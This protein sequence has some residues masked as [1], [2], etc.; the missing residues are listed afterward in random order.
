MSGNIY[1]QK[2]MLKLI[3]LPSD[4]TPHIKRS[5]RSIK[6]LG[7][8]KEFRWPEYLVQFKTINLVKWPSH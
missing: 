3:P 2:N 7:K 6:V 1:K 8:M 4:P 5:Q